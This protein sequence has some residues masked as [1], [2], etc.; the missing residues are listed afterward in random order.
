M[1][2]ILSIDVGGTRIK[3]AVIPNDVS[4][5]KLQS[6]NVEVISNR[7]WLNGNLPR[8]V[9]PNL[10]ASFTNKK[11]KLDTVDSI[12]ID[13]PW[14]VKPTGIYGYY[15]D[16]FGIPRDLSSKLCEYSN[17]KVLNCLNDA[18]AWMK[19]MIRYYQLS[20]Q[21]IVFPVLAVILG[22]GTGLAFADSNHHIQG[23]ELSAINSPF[24]R[25][26]RYEKFNYA[27]EIHNI[28]SEKGF[29]GSL[30]NKEERKQWDYDKV[31]AEYTLRIG[32][33]V[34]DILPALKNKPSTIIVGGGFSEY[35]SQRTVQEYTNIS[36]RV[37][38]KLD[39]DIN[40]DLIPL[41]GNI[42]DIV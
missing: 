39:L 4:L 41:I 24:D 3:A 37:I 18:E 8:I 1:S 9:D 6:I 36:V 42:T 12:A 21:E 26:R 16:T 28:L 7:G 20:K 14:G 27:Y 29:F 23:I 31:R 33:L 38:R 19:G 17:K 34:K 13:G 15:V 22:T 2:N 32:G 5:E 25:L 40:P 10:W 35:V 11:F 30:T